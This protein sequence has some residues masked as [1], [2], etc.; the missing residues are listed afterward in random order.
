M[1]DKRS[2]LR[3]VDA[4][5]HLL[6]GV[7]NRIDFIRQITLRRNRMLHLHRLAFIFQ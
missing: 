2:L 5:I 7:T 1:A 3:P 4:F 6:D